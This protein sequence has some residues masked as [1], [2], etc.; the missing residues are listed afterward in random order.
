M[1]MLEK[2]F[3]KGRNIKSIDNGDQLWDALRKMDN[4]EYIPEDFY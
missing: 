1:L 3:K 4:N 2:L